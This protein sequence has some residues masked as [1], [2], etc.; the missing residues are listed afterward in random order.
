MYP[1]QTGCYFFTQDEAKRIVS[2]LKEK[3]E[4]LKLFRLNLCKSV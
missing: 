2:W 4:I 1:M 3:F